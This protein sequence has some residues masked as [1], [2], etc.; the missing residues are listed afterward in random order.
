MILGVCGGHKLIHLL[1]RGREIS[2]RQGLR[3]VDLKEVLARRHR[4][5]KYQYICYLFHNFR[6]STLKHHIQSEREEPV[7]QVTILRIYVP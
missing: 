5:C 2:L 4:P 3:V 6:L 1:Q 7:R